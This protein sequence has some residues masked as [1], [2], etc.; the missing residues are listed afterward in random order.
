MK[1]LIL[2][3]LV[4]LPFAVDAQSKQKFGVISCPA[5]SL[6]DTVSITENT[7]H[8]RVDTRAEFPG[9]NKAFVAYFDKNLKTRTAVNPKPEKLRVFVS[10]VVEKDGSLTDVKVRRSSAAAS[11]NN[12]IIRIV[13]QSPA[14]NPAVKE[15]KIVRSGVTIPITI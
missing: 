3:C 9:G 4:V 1:S 12:D 10:F 15:G 6:P 7:I 11:V 2:F 5:P 13:H 14:W 8:T